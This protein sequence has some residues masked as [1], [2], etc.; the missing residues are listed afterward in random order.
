VTMN[1]IDYTRSKGKQLTYHIEADQWG[2]FKVWL[3][4]QLLL[5]GHD[6]LSAH[7]V[8]RLPSKRKA[9]GALD[10]ARTAIEALRD[11]DED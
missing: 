1:R 9:A 7:G 10:S 8:H 6:P 3:D 4:G 2:W 5:R 11:M